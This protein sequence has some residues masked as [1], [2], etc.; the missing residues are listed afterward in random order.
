MNPDGSVAESL[1]YQGFTLTYKVNTTGQYITYTINGYASLAI[2]THNPVL[3][4]P[5][6]SGFVQPSAIVEA[7]AIGVKATSY[8]DLDIDHNDAPTLVNHGAMTTSFSSYVRGT[9]DKKDDYDTFPGL[10]KLSKSY[11]GS[12]EAGGL[13]TLK[14]TQEVKDAVSG[15]KKITFDEVRSCVLAIRILLLKVLG[16]LIG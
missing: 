2:Q 8:Y 10:L 15:V 3:R 1:S 9:Y 4:I 11:N 14:S 6:V 7:L 12:R 5:A 13:D 16:S